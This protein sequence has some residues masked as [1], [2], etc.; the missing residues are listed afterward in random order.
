MVASLRFPD[1]LNIPRMPLSLTL[2]KK[3][4]TR[5]LPGLE[6]PSQYLSRSH[7]LPGL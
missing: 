1:S 2:K 4:E 7:I 3:L 5:S 6:T